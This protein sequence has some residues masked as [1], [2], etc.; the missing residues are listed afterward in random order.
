MKERSNE[1]ELKIISELGE[2]IMKDTCFIELV[3]ENI[4]SIIIPRERIRKLECTPLKE[5][6]NVRTYDTNYVRLQ[7][8]YQDQMELNYIPENYEYPLGMFIDNP[9]SNRVQDRPNILGRILNYRDIVSLYYMDDKEEE[10]YGVYVPWSEAEEDFNEY[11]KVS[12]EPSY[13]DILIQNNFD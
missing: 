7:I 6:T 5:R 10:I 8:D 13:I 2:W 3:F 12:I 4:E 11:M 9:T 1:E